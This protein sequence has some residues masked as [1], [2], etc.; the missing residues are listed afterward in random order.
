MEVGLGLQGFVIKRDLLHQALSTYPSIPSF[1]PTDGQGLG[2]GLR[3]EVEGLARL[4]PSGEKGGG[5]ELRVYE[6]F[7]VIWWPRIITK[8]SGSGS[9][10][11]ML[12]ILHY[13]PILCS[14]R[15]GSYITG[16][17]FLGSRLRSV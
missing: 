3:V 1:R 11:R 16:L 13:G 4:E 8:T 7:G 6:V 9:S 12:N 17:T 5:W 15:N 14:N 2:L 10:S